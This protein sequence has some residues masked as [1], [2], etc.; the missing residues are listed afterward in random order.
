MALE[1]HSMVLC[2]ATGALRPKGVIKGRVAKV[3]RFHSPIARHSFSAMQETQIGLYC[4]NCL[5]S[6]LSSISLLKLREDIRN[7]ILIIFML[8]KGCQTKLLSDYRSGPIICDSKVYVYL[9]TENNRYVFQIIQVTGTRANSEIFQKG[10][11]RKFWEN[12]MSYF[13]KTEHMNIPHSLFLLVSFFA[14]FLL[15]FS[16]LRFSFWDSLSFV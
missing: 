1:S 2:V 8:P 15:L 11:R 13:F 3:Q 16:F 12:V 9:I 10:L 14:L 7:L 4:L 5:Y 6:M